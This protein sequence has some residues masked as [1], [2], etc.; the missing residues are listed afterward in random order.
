M[1]N[2][3]VK[4][5]EP[6]DPKTFSVPQVTQEEAAKRYR[7]GE[8]LRR[9]HHNISPWMY[10]PEQFKARNHAL[11]LMHFDMVPR[12][13]K[14]L[15]D[16]EIVVDEYPRIAGRLHHADEMGTIEDI[17]GVGYAP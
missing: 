1:T 8:F 6:N 17:H 15:A 7:Q 13:M 16:G 9:N 11:M 14:P 10:T 5:S 12:P 4:Y 3:Y 2:S